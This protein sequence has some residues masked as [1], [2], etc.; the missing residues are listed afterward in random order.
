MSTDTEALQNFPDNVKKWE[1]LD[2]LSYEI[3][4]QEEQRHSLPFL[5]Y[6]RNLDVKVTVWRVLTGSYTGLTRNS[7]PHGIGRLV[8]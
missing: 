3:L 7:K 2:R 1:E 8:D 4:A 6:E 5:Q